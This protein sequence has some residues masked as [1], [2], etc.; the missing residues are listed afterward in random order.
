MKQRVRTGVLGPVI[1]LPED[2]LHFTIGN[3][4]VPD[5]LMSLAVTALRWVINRLDAPEEAPF[6]K[7]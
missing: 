6:A 2:R 5:P 4:Q 3:I 1:D 7:R